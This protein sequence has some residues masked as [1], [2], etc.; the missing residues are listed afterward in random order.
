LFVSTL[1]KKLAGKSS[2]V[3]SFVPKGF[4]YKYQIEELFIVMVY[5]TYSQ[6][7]KFQLFI[8]LIFLT[9]P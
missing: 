8:A 1:A 4:P 9:V 2:L 5:Y 3:I 7:V 6:H